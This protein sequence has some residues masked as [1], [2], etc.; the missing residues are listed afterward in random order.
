M[1]L[2]YLF[3]DQWRRDAWG[4]YDPEILTPN[5]NRLAEEGAVFDRAYSSCPLCSPN[6]ACL[7]TGKQPGA[8]NVF[9]NCKPD[10]DAHLKEDTLCV[11][12][13]LK[14]EGYST[15]YIGKWHLDRPD[16]RGGW[17]AYT[18]PGKKRH[19]FDFWYSYGTYNDH[20]HP[21]YWDTEG[22]YIEISRWSP[23]H[24][25]D[26]AL[27]FLQKNRGK[28]FA[29]FLSFNPPHPPY[30]LVP[31]KYV[32]LYEGLRED[33]RGL[34]SG[35]SSAWAPHPEGAGD[36]VPEGFDRRT[37][38]RQY[39]GAITGID[40]NIG[41]IVSWLKENRLYEDTCLMISADHG[42][43]MG[44]HQLISKHIWY[45]GSVG[46]PLLI[47]GGGIR[48]MRTKELVA[49]EDQAATILGLLGIPV[50]ACMDGMDFSPLLR[51]EPFSGHRSVLTMAFPNTGERIREYEAHGLNFMD[52]GWRCVVTERY[53][54]AVNR[55]QQYG[56]EPQTYLYD[57]EKDPGENRPIDDPEVM[58]FMRSEL[59]YWCRKNRDFFMEVRK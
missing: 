51:G 47:C 42:D 40:E 48:P 9:T 35:K 37:A 53:K 21:H 52:F 59:R 24:E 7:L 13:V 10:V 1:N 28:R 6:R 23:E 56:M 58:E 15:G 27:D 22:N 36:P 29:L 5:L 54:L 49:G 20:L 57:L 50:P 2:I 34:L 19:G 16:G 31:E 4:L 55:G 38:V 33:G 46:I 8:T 30:E 12:D 39:C 14:R 11:S 3:A 17:D 43:M 25:T 41:R 18:P 45:E 26:V 32:R 44:D